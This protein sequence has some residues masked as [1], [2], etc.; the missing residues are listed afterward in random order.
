MPDSRKAGSTTMEKYPPNGVA[1]PWLSPNANNFVILSYQ[2]K[3]MLIVAI[4]FTMSDGSQKP[5][6]IYL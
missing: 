3:T 4:I 6:R 2:I 5:L 1:L